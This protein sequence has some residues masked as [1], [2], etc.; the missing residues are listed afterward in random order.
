RLHDVS[1]A[2]A[3]DRI[4]ERLGLYAD[5]RARTLSLGNLQRLGLA[6]ALLHEPDLVVLDE[7]PNGLDPAGVVEIRE[8]F[9]TLARERGVTF[10]M[11]SHVLGEVERTATRIGVIH[12]GRV[13]EELDVVELQRHRRRWLAVDARDRAAARAVLEQEGYRVDGDAADALVL[14]ESRAVEEPDVVAGVLVRAGVP[15][16]RL[17]VEKE[18][19]EDH[20]LRLTGG[21]A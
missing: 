5:H 4:I 20:F 2:S 19:L 12:C 6:R 16:T 17:A 7:P 15:L 21:A 10:F 14:S 9:L 18:A 8:L 11:S 1:D 13:V 3:T